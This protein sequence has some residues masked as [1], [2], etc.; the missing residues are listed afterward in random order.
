MFVSRVACKCILEGS[1]PLPLKDVRNR[2][3]AFAVMRG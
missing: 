3:A 2:E 1:M